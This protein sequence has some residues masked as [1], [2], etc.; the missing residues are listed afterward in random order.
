VWRLVTHTTGHVSARF[1][2]VHSSGTCRAGRVKRNVTLIRV[3]RALLCVW[4]QW[5]DQWLAMLLLLVH[6]YY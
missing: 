4:L 5:V 2:T 6:L 1:E 3:H